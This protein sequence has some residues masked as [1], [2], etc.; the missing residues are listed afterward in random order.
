MKKTFTVRQGALDGVEA[1]L[2]V[3][4]HRKLR[5]FIDHMKSRSN[6]ANKTR[7]YV[8]DRRTRPR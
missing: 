3:A 6:V 8:D 5:A 1:F 7:I 2:S 4:Q